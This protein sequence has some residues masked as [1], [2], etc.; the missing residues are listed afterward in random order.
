MK[1]R[2]ISRVLLAAIPMV[3]GGLLAS[4]SSALAQSNN[5]PCSNATLSGD[6]GGRFAGRILA[7]AV[8]P[9]RQVTGVT[10][11]HFDGNGSFTSVEHVVFG[12][13]PPPPGGEW[14]PATGTYTVNED[15]TGSSV[16]HS[17]NSPQ[18]LP[19]HFV[20]VDNG[21]KIQSVVDFGAFAAIATK[22]S[23]AA[24]PGDKRCSNR[25][26]SGD[27]GFTI[28]GDLI[29][30]PNGPNIPLRTLSM[31]HFD[32]RGNMTGV[33]HL[34]LNGVPPTEEWREISGTYSVNSDCTGSGEIIFGPGS[35]LHLHFV[36]VDKGREIDQV[37]D[38][39][40]VTSV[41]IKFR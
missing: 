24:D 19:Q 35:S 3:I 17:A 27:Y 16:T 10:L 9:E 26:L 21:N 6:Y 29:L 37:V 2:S 12:G 32:G 14:T 33:D 38:G 13:I 25:T 31:Q 30:G 5:G 1:I 11:S 22:V 20:V 41:G 8:D 28:V 15:C 7:T 23:G 36:V 39:N 34:V 18:G 40:A 4:G